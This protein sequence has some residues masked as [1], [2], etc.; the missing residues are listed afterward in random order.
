MT[1]RRT[2][3][4]ALL[5]T[6]A[7]LALVCAGPAQTAVA[8]DANA[9]A[10]TNPTA[11]HAAA[12]AWPQY[13]GWLAK[14]VQPDGQAVDIDTRQQQTTT[15][16]QSYA[17]F[18][19]LVMNDRAT[20]D[21]VLDWTRVNLAGGR[22]G[23]DEARLPA[24]QWGRRDNGDFGVLDS[25]SASDSDLWIAYDLFE[26]GRLWHEASYTQTA[27][28]LL[29]Q[30]RANE[31]MT[32]P[33]LGPMLL[34]GAQGF[35]RNGLA[36]FNP[37]YTPVFVL[38]RLAQEDP[39]GPWDAIAAN[40]VEMIRIVSPHGFVPD[41]TA[42]HV[43][44]GFV[45]DPE[46]GDLGS[47]DAIRTYLWAALLPSGD[48]LSAKLLGSLGGMRATID[49]NGALPERVATT[50]GAVEHSAPVGFWGALLPYLH[51]LG[52]RPAVALAQGH[53]ANDFTRPRYF[54]RALAMFGTG[55]FDGRY[56][57]DL[58]GRLEPRWEGPC[59]SAN[60]R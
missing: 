36:R 44:Q 37:S 48:P 12:C 41:W 24:W 57:F 59:L 1:A 17:M 7:A 20:F 38:R 8:A 18:F 54:D 10:N 50:T 25:N 43:G 60:A 11:A 30:I 49:A 31:T 19:A 2:M 9:S 51:A 16:A 27:R 34:P 15:E 4:A 42:F 39:Q 40:S 6:L 32:L 29:S 45:V 13:D 28:A 47:Y 22:F 55:A 52:D 21:R 53:L 3:R 58:Q 33:G 56:R 26:A 5:P 14:V 23:P 46:K 35:F